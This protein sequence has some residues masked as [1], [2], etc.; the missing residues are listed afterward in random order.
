MRLIS[1]VLLLGSSSS[2]F[3]HQILIELKPEATRIRLVAFFED[4]SPA[5]DAAVSV[6]SEAGEVVAQGKTD[7]N[8]VWHFARPKPGN[9]Q[10]NLSS[11][12]HVSKKELTIPIDNPTSE[13]PPLTPPREE[14]TRTPWWGLLLGIV[15]IGALTLGWM[16]FRRRG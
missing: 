13:S 9:Y 4:D 8:G 15:G 2:L 11:I 12:G 10:I 16:W 3:A 7:A 1:L 6:T 5:D 14:Q